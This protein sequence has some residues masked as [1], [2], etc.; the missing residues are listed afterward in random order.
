MQLT[1]FIKNN[2]NWENTLSNPP[3][4]LI[5]KRK[6]NYVL[7]KYNQLSSDFSNP[8]VRE[9]RGVI[10]RDGDF[11]VVSRAFDKFF[12]AE[13]EMADNIDW[14]SAKVQEKIDG[15][16]ISVWYDDCLHISTSGTIDADDAESN[17][18]SFGEIFDMALSNSGLNRDT[19][20]EII[21]R[22]HTTIFEL[23]SPYNRVVIPYDETKL[24]LIGERDLV[25]MKELD[26]M[27]PS[28]TAIFDRPKMFDMH[29]YDDVRS[30]ANQMSWDEEGFVV[31]D[32]NFHRVKIKSTEWLKARYVRGNSNI[33]VRNL[34]DVVMSGEEDEFLVYA[35]DYIKELN[36]VK[37]SLNK[38]YNAGNNALACVK[39]YI[40]DNMPR[41]DYAKEVKKFP[42][43]VQDYLFRCYSNI[44]QFEQYIK[45][46]DSKKIERILEEVNRW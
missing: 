28:L 29:S 11:T 31:V 15:S 25:S 20:S 7:F 12:N 32:K 43:I 22:N 26:K 45:K 18:Y 4:S 34:I 38:L 44:E 33:S 21:D 13:E 6:N 16:I 10:L 19:L 3:Y 1:D 14:E 30:V 23:V 46:L 41:A 39:R 8:I 35:S 24:F 17:M 2:E 9:A 40:E 42:R 27:N 36:S 5:I 37:D